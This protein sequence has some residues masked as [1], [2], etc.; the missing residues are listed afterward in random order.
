MHN[1]YTGVLTP[2]TPSTV[3]PFS[4]EAGSFA[5]VSDHRII[6]FFS[7]LHSLKLLFC[8]SPVLRFLPSSEGV[9]NPGTASGS[10]TPS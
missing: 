1:Q 2:E 10:F 3:S 6:R 8:L 5:S 9:K 7:V 4:S